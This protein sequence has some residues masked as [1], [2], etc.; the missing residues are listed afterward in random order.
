MKVLISH[1]N[2]GIDKSEYKV[3]DKFINLV[4]EKPQ[5]LDWLNDINEVTTL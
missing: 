2:S 4:H 1:K 3:Y 5:V